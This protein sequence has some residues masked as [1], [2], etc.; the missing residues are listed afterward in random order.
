[1]D[2]RS[3]SQSRPEA[4][5]GA[6]ARP[7]AKRTI[8]VV[9]DS[10]TDLFVITEVIQKANVDLNVQVV[11]DGQEA[12]LYLEQV[13]G[14]DRC[15]VLVL[16]DLN[17]PKISG[18]EVLRRLRGCVRCNQTPVIVVTSSSAD[19]DRAAAKRL[20][21]EEYFQKPNDLDAYMQLAQIIRRVLNVT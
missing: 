11:K 4:S 5:E 13:A 15:P 20:G 8:L 12:L 14:A 3:A 10:P 17:L 7:G 6:Y 16:L 1:M 21:A 9:E 2:Q 18:I 19:G